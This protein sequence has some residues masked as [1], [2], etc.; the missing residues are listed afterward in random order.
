MPQQVRTGPLARQ[1]AAAGLRP[2]SHGRRRFPFPVSGPDTAELAV[3][4]LYTPGAQARQRA[5][6]VAWLTRMAP[7]E[8]PVPLLRFTATRPV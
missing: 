8:L 5:R 6:A 4:S 7:M 1:L 2:G 3:D